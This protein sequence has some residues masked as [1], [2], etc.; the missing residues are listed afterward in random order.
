MAVF[1]SV[2]LRSSLVY[3]HHTMGWNI[4]ASARQTLYE[5]HT[6]Y[7]T[8]VSTDQNIVTVID[9]NAKGRSLAVSTRT[10]SSVA[11]Q[12]LQCVG[13]KTEQCIICFDNDLIPDVRKK[14]VHKARAD[15]ASAASKKII[16]AT[17]TEI[18]SFT[19]S[20]GIE[21]ER[22]FC[23]SAGKR[24][25]LLVL[26]KSLKEEIITA[27]S[28]RCRFTITSPDATDDNFEA[29]IWSYPFDK[30]SEYKPVLCATKYGEA[31]AQIVACIRDSLKRATDAGVEPPETT[32]HT[33]D[34]DVYLQ[35]LS[36][37]HPHLHVV[38]GMV[39]KTSDG[40][41]HS[42][43]AR[44]RTAASA[45]RAV[46]RRKTEGRAV[47]TIERFHKHVSLSDF[48]ASSFS[49]NIANMVN[50][51]WW[52]LLTGGCDYNFTGLAAFGWNHKTCLSL[53]EEMVIDYEH[54]QLMLGPFAASLRAT[55]NAR[56]RNGEVTRF[57]EMLERTVY[58]WHYYQWSG[59]QPELA[60]FIGSIHPGTHETITDWLQAVPPDALCALR[61]PNQ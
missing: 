11:K 31:E 30:P 18:A 61:P 16:P 19:G 51:Q 8:S 23:T 57:C 27:A 1:F 36:F 32:I 46:K 29:A 21:W 33:I 56:R 7:K 54:F 52:F 37:T 48:A 45:L 44:A 47:G 26:V 58:C 60:Q 4:A 42:S 41:T 13:P 35:C 12:I 49:N 5:K 39:W 28:S 2:C 53:R 20:G 43:A 14:E 9:G 40:E 3:S 15:R 55:R 24:A 25:A 59:P 6:T 17:P 22:L 34:T 50:A 10:A 38:I